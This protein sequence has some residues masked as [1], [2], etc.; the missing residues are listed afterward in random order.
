[1]LLELILGAVGAFVNDNEG[2]LDGYG[3]GCDDGSADGRWL[4]LCDGRVD[5]YNVG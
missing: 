3:D 2:N 5:G 4:G 1:M